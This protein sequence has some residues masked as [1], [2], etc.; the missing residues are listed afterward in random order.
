MDLKLCP[1]N[2]PVTVNSL[3]NDHYWTQVVVLEVL[4]VFVGS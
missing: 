4:T 1:F 2:L 3:T